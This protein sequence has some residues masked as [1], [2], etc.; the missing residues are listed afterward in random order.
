[1]YSVPGGAVAPDEAAGKETGPLTGLNPA[2]RMDALTTAA[3][4]D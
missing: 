3:A 1:M 2:A 4:A